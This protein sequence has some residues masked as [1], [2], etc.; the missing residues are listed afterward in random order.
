MKHL[1]RINALME[2][3]KDQPDDLFLNYATGIEHLSQQVYSE[4]ETQFKKVIA[5]K[6]NHLAAYYQLAKVFE[7]QQKNAEALFYYKLGLEKAQEEK[8]NKTISE[9]KEAIFLLE[10]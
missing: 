2:M 10:D 9:F 7:E 4:A 6:A 3:L 5:L 8:D 1:N